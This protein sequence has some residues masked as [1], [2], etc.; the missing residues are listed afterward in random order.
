MAISG[1]KKKAALR[2]LRDFCGVRCDLEAGRES[3]AVE[4][5]GVNGYKEKEDVECS[6]PTDADHA[7]VSQPSCERPTMLALLIQER[8]R[9]GQR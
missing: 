1:K 4:D 5:A 7:A 9:A 3:G 8:L 2:L 6:F